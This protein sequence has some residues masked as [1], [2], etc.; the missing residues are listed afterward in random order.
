M[1]SAQIVRERINLRRQEKDIGNL[2]TMLKELGIGKSTLWAM[3]DNKGIGCFALA[4]IADRLETSTDYLLGRTDEA[5][6]I[7]AVSDNTQ[8]NV[9]GINSIQVS[10]DLCDEMTKEISSIL[11][12]LSFRQRTE[13]MGMIYKFVDE[14]KHEQ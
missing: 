10:T 9:N 14:N 7:I 6:M 3:T 8:N 5:N 11:S 2:E 13:L 12:E 1:Y 4:K